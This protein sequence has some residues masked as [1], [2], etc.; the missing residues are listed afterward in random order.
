MCLIALSFS[1]RQD[2]PLLVAANREEAFHRP[3]L[4]PHLQPGQPRVVCGIDQTAGG[5]WLGVNQ[6]GLMVA[7]TNRPKRIVPLAPRSRGLVCRELLTATSAAEAHRRGIEILERDACA[8]CNFLC[9]D[10]GE[11]W[12]IHA[13]DVL[14]SVALSPGLHLLSNGDL[15]DPHDGRLN[16]VRDAWRAELSG[17]A[18][19]F[20]AW[21]EQV[22]GLGPGPAGEP[23]IVLR[24][25]RRG[26]VSSSIVAVTPAA[27][28]SIY[29]HASGPP[30]LTPYLDFSPVLREVLAGD[31]AR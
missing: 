19:G 21:G 17:D 7:V 27:S 5:T 12:V 20:V 23:P 15:N 24:K 29:R 28:E 25:E 11:G 31:S 9:V 14:E 18:N 13:G 30:D 1:A 26:T 6:H 4:A 16:R 3:A 8:G 10:Q 22:C 2:R